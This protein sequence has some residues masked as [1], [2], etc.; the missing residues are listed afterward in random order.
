MHEQLI[1]NGIIS[2]SMYALIAIGYTMVYGIGRFVNFA[3]GELFLAG[4]F[5]YYALHSQLGIPLVLSLILAVLSVSMMGIIVERVA[6]KPFRDANQFIPLINT[7]GISVILQ[8]TFQVIF[9]VDSKTLRIAQNVSEGLHFGSIII[10]PV[11]IGIVVTSIIVFLLLLL[12]LN[13]TRMGKAIRATAEDREIASVLGINVNRT[14]TATFAL[15]SGLAAVAG[16]LMGYDQDFSPTIGSI[17]GIKA[18]TAAVLGGIGSVPGAA[19]G[20][21]LIGLLES[22][23]AFYISSGYKECLIFVILLLLL[24][25]RPQ[26]L[27]GKKLGRF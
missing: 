15:G 5:I 27:L 6:F 25:F 17:T 21:V 23:L 13:K 16:I 12:F 9:G 7:I 19:L 20:G 18:F 3:H 10:T 24:F 22:Y 2:G 26:G 1:I 14:I 4:A 11:Q 8:S